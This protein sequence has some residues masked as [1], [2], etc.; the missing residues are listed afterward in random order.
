M[1]DSNFFTA[2]RVDFHADMSEPAIAMVICWSIAEDIF[3]ADFETDP[4]SEGNQFPHVTGRKAASARGS[5]K[6]FEKARVPPLNGI[7]VSRAI[8]LPHVDCVNRELDFTGQALH[9]FLG[10]PAVIVHPIR[11]DQHR[12]SGVLSPSRLLEGYV[13]DIEKSG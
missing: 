6:L 9:F 10:I 13:E 2:R 7:S 11:Y 5:R 8:R 4:F 1:R 3:M 12:L